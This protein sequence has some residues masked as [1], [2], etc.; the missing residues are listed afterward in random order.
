M[1]YLV[2]EIYE[3]GVFRPLEP[4]ALKE[5]QRV[6]IKCRSQPRKTPW[7]G[8]RMPAGSVRKWLLGAGFCRILPLISPR[9]VPD[10]RRRCR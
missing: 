8:S 9:I 7:L 4:V 3:N 6:A 2:D 10:E 5:H 1:T